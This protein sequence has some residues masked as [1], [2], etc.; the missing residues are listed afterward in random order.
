LT[1]TCEFSNSARG[2]HGVNPVGGNRWRRYWWK[3]AAASFDYLQNGVVKIR[4]AIAAV[5]GCWNNDRSRQF[6]Q[7]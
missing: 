1:P 4:S 7:V 5:R 2:G 3:E 6:A